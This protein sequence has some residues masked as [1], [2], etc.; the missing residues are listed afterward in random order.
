MMKKTTAQ[1]SSRAGR[2]K[3]LVYIALMVLFTLLLA[4]DLVNLAL[5]PAGGGAA[6][7]ATPPDG[8]S[9]D[10]AKGSEGPEWGAM[11]PADGGEAVPGGD[12]PAEAGGAVPAGMEPGEARSSL[13]T[14]VRRA[15]LPILIACL[16]GNGVCLFLLLRLRRKKT[17][18]QQ[19]AAV[20]AQEEG[21]RKNTKGAWVLP[22]CLV[23][24]VAVVVAMLPSGTTSVNSM[25]VHETVVAETAQIS[26]L[27]AGIAGAGTLEDEDPLTVQVPEVIAV[28]AYYVD[29]GDTVE[30][31]DPLAL[32]DRTS[33]TAAIAELQSVLEELDE[34]MEEEAGVSADGTISA[35]AAGRVKAIYAGEGDGVLDVMSDEGAL[36]LLSLDGLMAVDIDDNGAMAMGDAVQVLRPDG[37]TVAGRVTQ[38]A[39]GVA[40]VTV[41]DEGTSCGEHVSVSDGQGTALGEGELY[42]HSEL[43][44]TGYYGVV[45]EIAVSAEDTVE[46][47][48][49]LFILDDTGH[50]PVY[51][52]LLARRHELEVQMDDLFQLYEEGII[53]AESA[54]LIAGVPEDASIVDDGQEKENAA[55]ASGAQGHSLDSALYSSVTEL[56][57]LMS[58]LPGA[59]N[60]NLDTYAAMIQS[61]SADQAEL[62]LSKSPVTIPDLTDLSSLADVEMPESISYLHVDET[63]LYGY[64]DGQWMTL[65]LSELQVGTRL[66]LAYPAGSDPAADTPVWIVC[67]TDGLDTSEEPEEPATTPEPTITPEPTTTPE[68]PSVPQEPEG[69]DGIQAPSQLAQ[70]WPSM[71]QNTAY[72]GGA[73][74]P[75]GQTQQE[76]IYER[77]SVSQQQVLSIIPQETAHVTI[78]VDELDILAL[79]EGQTAEVTLDAMQGQSFTGTVTQIATTGSNEGGNTKFSVQISLPRTEQMLA[80]MNASVKVSTAMSSGVVTVPAAALVEDAGKTYIYTAYEEKTDSLGGLTEVETGLSDGE[81][82]EIRSGLQEGDTYYYRYADTVTYRFLPGAA[83][84]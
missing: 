19:E 59:E 3:G 20:P 58:A 81:L 36:L 32:V 43:K 74:S 84:R 56:K 82:V 46:Q 31:G 33:V 1:S 29:N 79:E 50:T 69:T 8:L 75:E 14:A 34:A 53:Y 28:S 61:L 7:G 2:R 17:G 40:T 49:T 77:Y 27:S 72:D 67:E 78:S 64:R 70:Q 22:A 66:V 24:A 42:I 68:D 65:T 44:V 18:E 10:S 41:M 47:G 35:S 16:A 25:T 4:G 54:G 26:D 60:G 52:A 11:I 80:G 21:P 6:F 39:D 57:R 38:V 55:L 71:A 23:L 76:P 37:T 5:S 73:S 45:E 30:A 62:S 13:M 15:W 51:E 63:P 9:F 83:G 48:E 12:F